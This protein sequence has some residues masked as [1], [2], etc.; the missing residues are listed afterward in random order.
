MN[1]PEG[2]QELASIVVAE[3]SPRRPQ[4][5]WKRFIRL[6]GGEPFQRGTKVY[7][8]A[9]FFRAVEESGERR[10][11]FFWPWTRVRSFELRFPGRPH[12]SVPQN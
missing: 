8:K 7:R 6:A 9:Y 11:V 1:K 3:I 10:F 2:I 12:V 4:C 5:L